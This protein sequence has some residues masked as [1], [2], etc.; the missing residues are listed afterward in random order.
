MATSSSPDE[1]ARRPRGG[2]HPDS[3]QTLGY[4]L[5]LCEFFGWWDCYETLVK[6]VAASPDG[7]ATIVQTPLAAM[8]G[9]LLRAQVKAKVERGEVV[10]AEP[11]EEPED[12][13]DDDAEAYDW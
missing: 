13:P 3:L 10:G 6:R 9:A 4:Y 7:V 1:E 12:Y 11:P 5:E 2:G 8:T